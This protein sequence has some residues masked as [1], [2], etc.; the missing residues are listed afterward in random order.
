MSRITSKVK[1]G[2]YPFAAEHIPAV[3][4]LFAPAS[5]GGLCLDPC[6]GEGEAIEALAR[7]LNLTP[8]ANE[9]DHDRAQACQA[10]FGLTRAMQGDLFQL[11]TPHHAYQLLWINPPYTENVGGAAEKRREFEMLKES[12]KWCQDG[13]YVAWVIYAHH[14]T[15]RAARFLLENSRAVDVYRVPGLH[16]NTY[17][18]IVVIARKRPKPADPPPGLDAQSLALAARCADPDTLPE[19]AQRD[20][21]IYRFPAPFKPRRFYFH[22]EVIT[23]DLVL[24]ALEEF[25]A[26]R[27]SAFQAVPRTP[28]PAADLEPIVPPRGGQI[29]LILA[30]GVFNGLVL[31]LD[32]GPAAVRGVVR[33]AEVE[34]TPEHLNGEQ[35]TYQ[36]KAQVTITLLHRQGTVTTIEAADSDRL[37]DF[38]K[39]HR[40]AFLRY[41]DDH[42][43][44]V[45]DFDYTELEPVFNR[46]FRNRPLPGRPVTGPFETQKHVAAAVYKTLQR[47]K[48]L[49]I[50]GEMGVGKTL[51]G[52]TLIGAWHAHQRMKPGQIA[53][54]MAPPHLTKKWAKE[55]PDAVPGT[56]AHVVENDT[57]NGYASVDDVMAFMREVDETPDRLHVL[58]VSK[59]K[60]KLGE[61]WEPA[62]VWKKEY[63]AQ[64]P[65]GGHPPREFRDTKG[66][67]L[68]GIHRVITRV[69]PICPRCGET[70]S[71]HKTRFE[72]AS[73][74]WL[75]GAPRTCYSCDN[76]LWQLKRRWS[77]PR[78]GEKFPRRNPRYPV[79]RLLRERFSSRIAIFLSDE[80]HEMK[81]ESSDQAQAFRD[82]ACVADKVVG[83]TG[84]FFGGTASSVFWLEWVLNP[85]M[86]EHYPIGELGIGPA[87][88]RWVDTM[89]VK[90]RVVEY[91][92]E[93]NEA[94]V[95]SGITRVEHAPQERP[96]IS[97]LLVRELI[98]HAVWVGLPDMAFQLPDY[99]EIPIP[100]DLPGE[101]QRHYDES[102]SQLIDYLLGR[103]EEG[104][105]S[106]LSTYLQSVLRYPSSCFRPKP[107]IHRLPH[108][109]EQGERMTKHVLTF[110]GFGEGQVYP[111]E[112]KLLD[113][114][115]DELSA[116]RPCAVFVAQ[117]GTLDIQPRLVDLIERHVPGAKVALMRSGQVPTDKRTDWLDKQL[118]EGANVLVC[119]PNLVKTGLDLLDFKTLIFY[120][121]DYNLYTTLQ[122]SRRHW[123]IGQTETCKVVYLY[124]QST[125]EA[126]AIELVSQKKAAASLLDGDAEGGGL[127]Q[128][129]GGAS[130]LEA[131]LAK[132]IADDARLV[133]ATRLFQ[134]KARQS[135]DFTSGWAMGNT[136]GKTDNAA[137]VVPL[138]NVIGQHFYRRADGQDRLCRVADY[139]PLDQATYVIRQVSD[140][141][142]QLVEADAVLKALQ[143][144]PASAGDAPVRETRTLVKPVVQIPSPSRP[145]KPASNGKTSAL[146]HRHA[147]KQQ[148]PDAV[149]LVRYGDF[150]EAV[151]NDAALLAKTL[152]LVLT[153]RTLEGER[154]QIAGFPVKNADNYLRRLVSAG[155]R[156]AVLLEPGELPPIDSGLA[157][158]RLTSLPVDDTPSPA[159]APQNGNAN[160]KAVQLA[161]SAP[162]IPQPTPM[163]E[164]AQLPLFG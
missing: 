30:A 58:I 59:E 84:T 147:V 95:F 103:R 116:G 137:T 125:M 158:Q 156:V 85:R 54:V 18:Q 12:W 63:I 21:A 22:P 120:E 51:L 72:L 128:I 152:S 145:V 7:A 130:S 48:S 150:Y 29:G 135:A 106:F 153:T 79:A 151:G 82:L 80:V 100:V 41:L 61:G 144:R 4:S 98:D 111:K 126:Q 77:G 161:S 17:Q 104:D 112:E 40:S 64:W 14:L 50:I 157:P 23:P 138:E 99:E 9:L 66:E 133:D 142:E 28:P 88:D 36:R 134:Q 27:L 74:S 47:R 46:A 91:R 10:R 2:Y 123:R 127:A 129:A 117:T 115:R 124:Y 97:P 1:G 132:S 76:P 154:V 122:A 71:K 110:K 107:V 42:S 73:K 131:E 5:Q 13:G 155:H 86:H 102:K 108:A 57:G 70:I 140:G 119:N 149:V 114:L 20:E 32:T 94:G 25:G 65:S 67:P 53:V 3:T 15:E 121:V 83:L 34:T 92:R 78:P 49:V 24:P 60:A 19:L 162:L 96:G 8:Y 26:Q 6:A 69:K 37:V 118:A 56:H 164:A 55:L 93:T 33:M 89:G 101:V 143:L 11:R 62:V 90:E 109:D 75:N 113:I 105:A 16:L 44:P 39:R 160:G 87:V 68:P 146:R 31:E 45:Y 81:G 35:E 148:H 141:T 159:I 43:Q 52:S 136:N 163:T 139:G 38:I